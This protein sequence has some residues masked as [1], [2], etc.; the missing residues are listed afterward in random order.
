MWLYNRDNTRNTISNLGINYPV[1]N[2]AL[3]VKMI[4]RVWSYSIAIMNATKFFMAAELG[5]LLAAMMLQSIIVLLL[6]ILRERR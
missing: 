5:L 4:D 1:E 6:Q 3:E 2:R